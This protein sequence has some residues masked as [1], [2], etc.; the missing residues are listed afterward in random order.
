MK[1]D[2]CS[3]GMD[4]KECMRV[5]YGIQDE[6]HIPEVTNLQT[7]YILFLLCYNL[8]SII[9]STAYIKILLIKLVV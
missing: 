4:S 7:H 5:W 3:T 8:L 1:S 6:I 2:V 9:Q